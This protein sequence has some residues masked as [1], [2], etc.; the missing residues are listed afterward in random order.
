MQR[1]FILLIK[2][3]IITLFSD[4]YVH[5]SASILTVKL[6]MNIALPERS[7]PNI[8][9]ILLVKWI[10]LRSHSYTRCDI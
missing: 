2:H 4:R 3:V 5:A 8:D 6:L 1:L 7:S 9:V 10:L